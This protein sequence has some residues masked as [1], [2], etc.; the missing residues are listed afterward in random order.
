[1]AGKLYVYDDEARR[2]LDNRKFTREFNQNRAKYVRLARR[3]Y[4][5]LANRPDRLPLKGDVQGLL[6]EYLYVDADFTGLILKL[7]QSLET[8]HAMWCGCFAAMVLD[9]A[10]E[11]VTR[12]EEGQ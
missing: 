10:W 3:L 1:V 5:M 8:R 9:Q 7:V 11:E 4:R 2:Q 12:N 6:S